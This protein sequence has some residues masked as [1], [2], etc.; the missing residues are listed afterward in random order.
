M[1]LIY[2]LVGLAVGSFLNVC[3]DRLPRG[4]TPASGVNSR[5]LRQ[6]LLHPPSHCAACGQSLAVRDLVPLLSYLLLHGRCRYCRV[7]IPKRLP[8]VELTTGLLFSLLWW[9]YGPT[10]ELVLAMVFTSFLIVI[11]VVDLE[12][13]IVPNR[14]VYPAIVLA[15]LAT[16]L[17][18][19][20]SVLGLLAG[21]GWGFAILLAIAIAWPG[22]MGMG[23][24]KLA[25]FIG[26]AVGA[27]TIF[28]GLFMS[29][30]LGATVSVGLLLTG[31]KGR[32]DRIPFAPFLAAGG[33]VAMLYGEPI[34]QWYIGLR[35]L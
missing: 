30:L 34:W 29:F 35:L 25:A 32:K 19:D 4:R 23:D 10:L 31:I 11:S 24:V 18:P 33:L 28:I 12:R 8:L 1:T 5:P 27:P 21:G 26:L 2:G 13:Q 9:H 15:L 6:S 7:P 14:I 22:G 20:H 3:I 17:T 16:P